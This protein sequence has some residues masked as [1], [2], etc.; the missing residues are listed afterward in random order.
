MINLFDSD[1]GSG[2]TGVALINPVIGS[3]TGRCDD[4]CFQH[5][6]SWHAGW[7]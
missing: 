3:N 4:W 6:V 5:K 1:L 7:A 2:A